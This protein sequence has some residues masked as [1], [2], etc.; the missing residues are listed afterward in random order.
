MTDSSRWEEHVHWCNPCVQ[1]VASDMGSLKMV[2]GV[3]MS[4][5]G[6]KLALA[7]TLR[8]DLDVENLLLNTVGV[9]CDEWG[10]VFCGRLSFVGTRP[11]AASKGVI[12]TVLGLAEFVD[13]ED[14]GLKAQD[15][16]DS[17]DEAGGVEGVLVRLGGGRDCRG[18]GVGS[19]C[20]KRH[21]GDEDRA[22]ARE[23]HHE[24]CGAYL[25]LGTEPSKSCCE[26]E[27]RCWWRG[28][29]C[30]LRQRHSKKT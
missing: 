25:T 17:A 11:D 30:S 15:Q 16:H 27:W 22:S 5:N 8:W 12:V 10:G 9:C 23:P 24:V 26:T 20:G 3:K 1:C 19:S 14:H 7:L 21:G 18:A 13:E 28:W 2:S 29:W 6:V 4:L